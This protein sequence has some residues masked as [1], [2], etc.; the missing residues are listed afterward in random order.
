LRRSLRAE[1]KGAEFDSSDDL[2]IAL[3]P[4]RQLGRIRVFEEPGFYA[5]TDCL[6]L[7]VHNHSTPI[8]FVS[9]SVSGGDPDDAEVRVIS[10]SIDSVWIKASERGQ[11]LS[12]ELAEKVAE[13]ATSFEDWLCDHGKAAGKVDFE[14]SAE[15]LTA[16]GYFFLK[17]CDRSIDSSCSGKDY[18]QEVRIAVG[19]EELEAIGLWALTDEAAPLIEP[20]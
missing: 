16:A 3:A 11:W 17:T 15:N 2:K 18:G 10:I 9:F 7:L 6:A 20:S 8:G 14:L 5:W 12:Y 1:G 4:R 19:H 13:A